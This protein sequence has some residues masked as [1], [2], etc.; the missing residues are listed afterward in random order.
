MTDL[1][2]GGQP[3]NE[4]ASRTGEKL[5]QAPNENDAL[6]GAENGAA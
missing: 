5:D 4:E 2:N 1:E 6:L 3:G